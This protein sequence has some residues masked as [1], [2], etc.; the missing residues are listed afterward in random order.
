[1]TYLEKMTIIS[2]LE[3]LA[4][5]TQS[6]E[7]LTCLSELRKKIKARSPETCKRTKRTAFISPGTFICDS[8][9]NDCEMCSMYEPKE[10]I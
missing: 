4:F 3:S 5:R 6:Y 1:M 10:E 8:P 7:V 2:C 9:V